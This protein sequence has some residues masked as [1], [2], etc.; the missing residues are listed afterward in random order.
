MTNWSGTMQTAP[1]PTLYSMP[2][3]AEPAP[4]GGATI[5][6]S[7]FAAGLSP[8]ALMTYCQSRLDS[9]DGQIQSSF[10]GQKKNSEFID[11][12]N[13]LQKTFKS[14]GSK[15]LDDHGQIIAMETQYKTLIE[16]M[17]KNDPGNP[18]LDTLITSYNTLVWSGSGGAAMHPGTPD[19]IQL[20]THPPGK[21]SDQ[22]DYNLVDTEFSDFAQTLSDCAS[23]LNSHAELQMVQLQS[24]MSQRQTAITM[25]TNLVQSLGD[26]ENK[27]ADNIGH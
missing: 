19:F 14:L 12:M 24:L 9:I 18:E 4:I 8:E 15:P 2:S 26:Q 5:G 7:P 17:Q 22:G 11:Q 13:T 23:N 27:I 16:D 10:D 6:D 21:T 1:A 25:T 3:L 20:D